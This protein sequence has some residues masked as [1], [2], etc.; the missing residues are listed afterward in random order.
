VPFPAQGIQKNLRNPALGSAEDI[1]TVA[2]G[3]VPEL[4]Q[5]NAREL[6]GAVS[7]LAGSLWQIA[8]PPDSLGALYAREPQPAHAVDFTP[9][10]HRLTVAL[11]TGFAAKSAAPGR[12]RR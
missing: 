12:R 11:I 9:K 5:D 3:T 8:H 4:D 2:A 10:L 1:A 6:I 7:F